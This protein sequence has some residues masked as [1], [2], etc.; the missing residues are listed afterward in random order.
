M[1]MN[2]YK[3]NK[4]QTNPRPT[5]TLPSCDVSPSLFLSFFLFLPQNA[6]LLRTS[7]LIYFYGFLRI[8]INLRIANSTSQLPSAITIAHQSYGGSLFSH[9]HVSVTIKRNNRKRNNS[10]QSF[11]TT[12]NCRRLR[13]AANDLEGK[14]AWK[15]IPLMT[16]APKRTGA[17]S[18]AKTDTGLPHNVQTT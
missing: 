12:P 4:R 6:Y 18:I 17:S 13:D 9:A 16:R 14:F 15:V 5:I 7:T 2:L 11:L 10:L 1:P 3:N 8:R